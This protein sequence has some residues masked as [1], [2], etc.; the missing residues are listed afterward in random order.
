[1]VQNH[2]KAEFWDLVEGKGKGLV[3]LLHGPP[4]VGKTLTAETLARATGKP[5]LSVSTAEIGIEPIQ[6]ERN[7]TDIFEDA[8][9]WKA[10]LLM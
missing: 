5:L 4:G 8:S 3:I 6:A 7:F 1:V 2:E 10:I 9:R